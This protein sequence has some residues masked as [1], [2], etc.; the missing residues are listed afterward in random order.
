MTDAPFYASGLKFTCKRCSACC[1]YESG[2]VFLSEKDLEK[3]SSQI[4]ADKESFIK[5]YCRWIP[6]RQGEETLSLKEKLNKDCI[7]WDSGCTVY[8]ARPLQCRTFPFWESVAVSAHAWEIAAS[9]CPGINTGSLHSGEEIGQCIKMRGA[10]PVIN[11]QGD[12]GK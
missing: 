6:G 4:G 10:E 5:M 9:G 8:N 1:R 7:L 2:F 3:L 12:F 11:R